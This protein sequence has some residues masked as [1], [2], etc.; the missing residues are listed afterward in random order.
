MRPAVKKQIE[1]LGEKF[2]D[3]SLET[4]EAAN[5]VEWPL[6]TSVR[7][8]LSENLGI[9]KVRQIYGAHYVE[10]STEKEVAYATAVPGSFRTGGIYR[11]KL[12]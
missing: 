12:G 5:F 3:V 4:G 2:V 6:E 11:W 8:A 1:S 7:T 10:A 9:A